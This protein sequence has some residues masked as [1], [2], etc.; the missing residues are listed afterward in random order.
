MNGAIDISYWALALSA[1]FALAPL[2]LSAVFRLRLGKDVVV[3]SLRMSA[4]LA[5]VGFFLEYLF[6]WNNAWLNVAWFAAMVV[7]AS[8][9]AVGRSS[10]NWRRFFFPM[11]AAF[12]IAGGSTTLLLNVFVVDLE[13]P[14]SARYVIAVGGMLLSNSMRGTIVGVGDFY[15][16]LRRDEGLYLFRL[17]LGATFFEA[18]APYFRRSVR[19]ALKPTIAA[20]ATMG[21]V[22]LPGMMTGQLL[23]GSSPA[24][25]VKYQI[26][27]VF[28]ILGATTL[29]VALGIGLTY[30]FAI[31]AY[32]RLKEEWLDD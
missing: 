31:D 21:V 2:A 25:A 11:F 20:M 26:A 10:L 15:H 4:Q 17:T 9:A 28:A 23:G 13:N 30:R 6:E 24:V 27:I 7:F 16:D 22:S 8:F 1:A 19:A 32:G 29:T 5:L 12:L 14:F 18:A 3:S